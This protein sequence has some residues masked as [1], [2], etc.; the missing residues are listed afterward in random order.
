VAFELGRIVR[1]FINH[2]DHA[3]ALKNGA[4]CIVHTTTFVARDPGS[5]R[6]LFENP[7]APPGIRPML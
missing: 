2:P 5:T 1:D 6:G 3:W 4:P 7:I